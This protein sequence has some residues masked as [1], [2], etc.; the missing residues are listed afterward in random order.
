MRRLSHFSFAAPAVAPRPAR[1]AALAAAAATGAT[2]PVAVSPGDAMW[3]SRRVASGSDW[4]GAWVRK[5]G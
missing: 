4:M 1:S 3:R 2:V 5:R